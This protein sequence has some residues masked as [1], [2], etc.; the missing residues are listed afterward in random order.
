MEVVGPAVEPGL[1]RRAAG[2]TELSARDEEAPAG[3]DDVLAAKER[4]AEGGGSALDDEGVQAEAEAIE[5]R[6]DAEDAKR[7]H[8]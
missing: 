7:K 8:R 1:A 4:E 3:F 5:A 2:D 6:I